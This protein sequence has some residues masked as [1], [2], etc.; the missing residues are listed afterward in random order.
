[1][2]AFCALLLL[3]HPLTS[4]DIFNYIASARIFWVH[5]DNPLTTPPLAHPEDRFFGMLTFWQD[6]PSPYGP[7]WSLLAGAPVLA[8]D[9]SPLRTVLAFK[10]TSVLFFLGSG[11]LVYLTARRIRPDSAVPAL[12]AL[13]WNP[14]AVFHVAGNGHND[15]VM[16]FFVA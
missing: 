5:G 6:V 13:S 3:T 1:S 11:W 7:L 2:A 15:A 4:T 12:L 16:V 8:G 10:A 9:G 14:L